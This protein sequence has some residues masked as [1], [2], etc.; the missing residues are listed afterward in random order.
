M[1]IYIVT[2]LSSQLKISVRVIAIEREENNPRNT[3]AKKM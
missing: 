3:N 1:Q 2:K